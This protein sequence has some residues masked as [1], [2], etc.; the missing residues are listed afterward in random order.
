M[1]RTHRARLAGITAATATAVVLPLTAGT[2]AS[3]AM[4]GSYTDNT[5]TVS[6]ARIDVDGGLYCT[7]TVIRTGLILTAK[8]C[9]FGDLSRMRVHLW[10]A[11]V[12]RPGSVDASMTVLNA[13]TMPGASTSDLTRYFYRDI[14]VLQVSG[15]PSWAKPIAY[16]GYW[17]GVGTTLTQYGYGKY[18][19]TG[20]PASESLGWLAKSPNGA[21][22]RTNC[23]SAPSSPS[24]P[25]GPI[26]AGS[27]CTWSNSA[28]PWAGDSGSALLWWS[29]GRWNIVGVFN[30]YRNGYINATNRW[31]TFWA[32][33]DT[34]TVSWLNGL[35]RSVPIPPPPPGF[36]RGGPSAKGLRGSRV[37]Q[38]CCAALRRWAW[39]AS[40][41]IIGSTEATAR[42]RAR[43]S[44]WSCQA[45]TS[46][47][48]S[49]FLSFGDTMGI[50]G[51]ARDQPT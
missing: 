26:F 20:D 28:W 15:M 39:R 5:M 29:S 42:A 40:F 31:R 36:H 41:Q 6:I 35:M 45:M 50:P 30:Q 21:I 23:K 17:P 12:D 25:S 14:A 22:W 34:A 2:G 47:I 33:Q 7:G 4:S 1:I 38:R 13:Y 51:Q 48:G 32:P 27:I 11:G 37:R 46:A 8:H 49:G 18:G 24:W 3:S 19:P 16:S 44:P 43:A 10:S 9:V